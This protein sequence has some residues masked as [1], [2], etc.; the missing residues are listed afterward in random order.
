MVKIAH[1]KHMPIGS[2]T[3]SNPKHISGE[4]APMSRANWRLVTN[5]PVEFEE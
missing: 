3:Y 4:L 2:I 1:Q 5:E